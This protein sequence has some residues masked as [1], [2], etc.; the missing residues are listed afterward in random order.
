MANFSRILRLKDSKI[1]KVERW[2]DKEPPADF[3]ETF[4]TV[5]EFGNAGDQILT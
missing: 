5:Q 1:A 2:A 4:K 3:L